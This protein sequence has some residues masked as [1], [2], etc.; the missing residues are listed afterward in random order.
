MVRKENTEAEKILNEVRAGLQDEEKWKDKKQLREANKELLEMFGDSFLY[1][2]EAYDSLTIARSRIRWKRIDPECLADL[3][4]IYGADRQA[5]A[6]QSTEPADG[7]KR[8]FYEAWKEISREYTF[9]RTVIKDNYRYYKRLRRRLEIKPEDTIDD[10]IGKLLTEIH[11]DIIEVGTYRDEETRVGPKIREWQ[12]VRRFIVMGGEDGQLATT[13]EGV[14]SFAHA[15][16][17]AFKTKDMREKANEV[18]KVL[19]DYRGSVLLNPEF[20]R[21]QFV[22]KCIEFG[23]YLKTNLS[24]FGRAKSKNGMRGSAY[25]DELTRVEDLIETTLTGLEGALNNYHIEERKRTND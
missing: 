2:S 11:G 23:G 19:S 9:Y 22:A 20:E 16:E 8:T 6:E 7:K 17:E 5:E 3:H 21:I 10:I 25:R 4:F 1:L 18:Q 14:P 12:T 13:E 24:D 15:L